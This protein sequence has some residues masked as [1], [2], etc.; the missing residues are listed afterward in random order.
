M[1]KKIKMYDL[2][3]LNLKVFFPRFNSLK[4]SMDMEEMGIEKNSN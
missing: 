1:K 3:G 2:D 4:N